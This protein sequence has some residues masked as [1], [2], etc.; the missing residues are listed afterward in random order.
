MKKLLF[1]LSFGLLAAGLAAQDLIYTHDANGNR[2][3]R[4][5]MVLKTNNTGNDS[6]QAHNESVQE[7]RETY[8]MG[9]LIVVYPNPTAGV[10][11]LETADAEA[12]EGAQV[13]VLDANGRQIKQQTIVAQQTEIDLSSFANGVYIVRITFNG[14]SKEW[15]VVKQ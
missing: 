10:I 14:R 12:L 3:I 15:R 9:N 13:Q 5:T 11:V 7:A 4:E 6:T 1:T 2:I 8:L